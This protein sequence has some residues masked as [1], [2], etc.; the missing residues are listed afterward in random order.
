MLFDRFIES[1]RFSVN[2]RRKRTVMK[3][4]AHGEPDTNRSQCGIHNH[5]SPD[6]NG[7]LSGLFLSGCQIRNGFEKQTAR[8]FSCFC[9][10]NGPF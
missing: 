8:R 4:V 1:Q 7:F 9:W 10:N 3:R 5:K 2:S 6:S